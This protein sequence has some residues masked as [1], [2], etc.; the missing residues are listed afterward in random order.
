MEGF[1]PEGHEQC[2]MESRP[3][4]GCIARCWK[5]ILDFQLPQTASFIIADYLSTLLAYNA[6][7]LPGCLLEVV[8]GG[9]VHPRGP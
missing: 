4:D 1:I 6:W 2:T 5:F 7:D 8:Q 3:A 9:G